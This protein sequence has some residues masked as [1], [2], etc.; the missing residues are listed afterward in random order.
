MVCHNLLPEKCFDGLLGHM[1]MDSL[2]YLAHDIKNVWRSKR[3]VTIILLDI[4]SAFPN[5]VTSCL[6]LNMRQLTYPMPLVN[7][8]EAML[9]D[10]HTTLAFD[11]LMLEGIHLML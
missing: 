1:T 3:V 2:L 9:H 8:Y 6:I 4:A 5:V 11:G 10:C 7:F